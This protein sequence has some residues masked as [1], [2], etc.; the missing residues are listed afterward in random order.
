MVL[1]VTTDILHLEP[2]KK[3]HTNGGKGKQG[4]RRIYFILRDRRGRERE[5][6]SFACFFACMV[7]T[8]DVK[9]I[10]VFSMVE[11]TSEHMVKISFFFF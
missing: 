7:Y 1:R 10:F 8:C 4:T 9:V 3:T 6:V 5:T 2:K 11:S